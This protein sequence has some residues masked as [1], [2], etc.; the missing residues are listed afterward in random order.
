MSVSKL[1]LTRLNAQKIKYDV[2]EHR[3]VYTAY[4]LAATLKTD[5]SCI[6]KALV[7]KA[8]SVIAVAILPAHRRLDMKK[9]KRVLKVN[10]VFIVSEKEMMRLISMKPG[11]LNVLGRFPKETV[12]MIDKEMV[13][14]KKVIVGVGSFTDSLVCTPKVLVALLPQAQIVDIHESTVVKMKKPQKQKVRKTKKSK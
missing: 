2:I 10:N 7:L 1:L 5:L 6:A 8:H 4:D 12:I 13:K 14:P 9:I 11:A 3:K